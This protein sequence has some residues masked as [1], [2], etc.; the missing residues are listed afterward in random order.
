[1]AND[2]DH[3]LSSVNLHGLGGRTV[4]VAGDLLE[5]DLTGNLDF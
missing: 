1:M 5:L 3:S 4:V 2:N